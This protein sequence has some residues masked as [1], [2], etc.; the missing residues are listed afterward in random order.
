MPTTR[1]FR[2]SEEG[3]DLLEYGLLAAL[4]AL[5]A[6]GAVT[7]VGNTIQTVFWIDD[8]QPVSSVAF[9]AVAAGVIAA[10]VIDI[11]TR[12]IPNLLTAT[13][14][15]VGFGLAA[16]GV[17]GVSLWASLLGL[18]VGLALMMPGHLL[19]AT[20]AGTSS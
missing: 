8:C 9:V 2:R 1:K 11:R 7:T 20:G 16:A 10:T 15:G 14:A 17:S 12:R 4:I 5:V 19:G 3:Q 13:M 18:V 6:L